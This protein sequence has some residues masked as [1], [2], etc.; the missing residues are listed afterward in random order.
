MTDD[1]RVHRHRPTDR[2]PAHRPPTERSPARPPLRRD[3]RT[4]ATSLLRWLV[5]P[6]SSQGAVAI[7]TVRLAISGPDLARRVRRMQDHPD[8]RRLLRERPE[9]ARHLADRAGLASLPDGSVGRAYLGF[10][11]R[12]EVVPTNLLAANLYADGYLDALGWPPEVEWLVE[13]ISMTHDLTH[14]LSGYG[15]SLPGEALNIAFTIGIEGFPAG[16]ALTETWSVLSGSV[17]RPTTG[18][19]EWR[20]L[21]VEAYERGAGIAERIPFECIP[22]EELL[23]Q[24]LDD[25]RERIGLRPTR[26]PVDATEDWI[27][28]ALGRRLAHGYGE[29]MQQK[30]SPAMRTLVDAARRGATPREL[31]DLSCRVDATAQG[32]RGAP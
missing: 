12:P 4:G 20:R 31:F 27:R 30:A 10:L 2:P 14:V 9:L 5:N 3:V 13:R 16:R 22:F 8:G 29:A 11:E 25:V 23:P 26:E 1:L 17:I 18:L 19:L 6:V 7:N 32:S 24:G 28:S 21:V 15:T